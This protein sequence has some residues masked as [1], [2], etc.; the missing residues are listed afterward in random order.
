MNNTLTALKG[1]RVGHS[2][3]KDKLTGCTVVLFDDLYPVAYKSYGGAPGTFSTENI[4]AGKSWSA[5]NGLFIAGGSLLGLASASDIMS[6]MIEH[7]LGAKD[8]KTIRPAISGAIVYDLGIRLAQYDPAYGREAAQNATN[9]PVES[10]N[11]GAGTG[12]SVGKFSYTKEFKMLNMKAGVGSSRVDLGN[13][14]MVCALSVVNALGNVILQDGKV[15]AG[16]RHDAKN[17]KFRSFDKTSEVF[18]GS[19]QNTTISI[20]GINVDLEEYANYETVAHMA[21]QGHV[22]AVSPVNT[23]LDGDTVFVFSTKEVKSP[24]SSLGK[25]VARNGWPTLA[26][27]IIGHA[28]AKAVQESIYDACRQAETIT[29]DAAYGN[30]VP[31]VK[32]YPG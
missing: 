20:V 27:D 17:P 10:G 2:T 15:L 1:V 4:R 26:T 29:L 3:H 28:A 22:R 31:S 8:G 14:V 5:R 25:S 19:E 18:T 6:Y 24:L 7:K 16:N 30:K 13:G 11:V 12:T 32:A 23:S 21:S 9:K